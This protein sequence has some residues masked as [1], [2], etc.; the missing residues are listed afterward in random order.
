LWE[1]KRNKPELNNP[2]DVLR[3]LPAGHRPGEAKDISGAGY[4]YN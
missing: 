4:L 3:K 2:Q 1:N